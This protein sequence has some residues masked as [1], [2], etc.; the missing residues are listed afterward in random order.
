MCDVVVVTDNHMSAQ[1]VYQDRQI[2]SSMGGVPD[3]GKGTRVLLYP[4]SIGKLRDSPVTLAEELIKR[5]V[6]RNALRNVLWN[7]LQEV[8]G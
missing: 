4:V 1:C 5:N 8:E 7:V 3:L 6:L 2:V